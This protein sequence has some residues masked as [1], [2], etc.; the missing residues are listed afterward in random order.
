MK[1]AKR[2]W[3][4]DSRNVDKI[5]WGLCLLCLLLV[6]PEFFYHRHDPF[7]WAGWIGFYGVYGFVSCVGLV[8]LA[9]QMRKIVK[10]R[11]DYYDR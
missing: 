5:F 10:R 2:Y 9:K 6:L 11:E 4:D 3:L 1:S 8:V 7:S